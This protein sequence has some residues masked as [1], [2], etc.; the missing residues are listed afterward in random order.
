M[1]DV[2]VNVFRGARSGRYRG[3]FGNGS[4]GSEPGPVGYTLP[5]SVLGIGSGIQPGFG[6]LGVV[7]LQLNVGDDVVVQYRA[8]AAEACR[9]TR[10]YGHKSA[11][12]G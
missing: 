8:A 12:R 9:D 4:V 7:Y 6:R 10:A 11:A 5:E 1:H 3:V 2:R